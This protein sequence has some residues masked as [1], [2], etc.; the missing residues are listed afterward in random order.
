MT[1]EEAIEALSLLRIF[2][3]PNLD[4]AVKMAVAALRSQV[5]ILPD[6]PLTLEQLWEM[7]GEPVWLSGRHINSYDVYCGYAISGIEQF[8]K[9]ALPADEYGKIWLAYRRRPEEGTWQQ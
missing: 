6:D 3:A 2:D 1:Q 5:D 9:A 7:D 4:E 8:Y